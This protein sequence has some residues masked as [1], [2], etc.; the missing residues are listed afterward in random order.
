VDIA[1]EKF[2]GKGIPKGDP[3]YKLP[4]QRYT[5]DVSS[6]ETQLGLKWTSLDK[7]VTDLLTQL[8]SLQ[9]KE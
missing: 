5:F 4:D 8:F 2:P 7:S 6:A 3:G 1:N 9:S